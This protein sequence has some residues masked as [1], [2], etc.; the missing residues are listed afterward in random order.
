MV[1]RVF[2]KQPIVERSRAACSFPLLLPP[3][4]S[5][6]GAAIKPLSRRAT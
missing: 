1:A 3:G 4:M 6:S 2:G 5:A